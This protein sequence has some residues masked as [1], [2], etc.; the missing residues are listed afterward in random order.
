VGRN[1]WNRIIN[2]DALAEAGM[3]SPEDVNL[4]TWTETAEETWEAIATFYEN[5]GCKI[6]G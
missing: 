3:I 2:L 5:K 6:E 4:V 1:F